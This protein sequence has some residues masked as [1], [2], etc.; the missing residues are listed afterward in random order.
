MTGVQNLPAKRRRRIEMPTYEYTE[1]NLA[2][3][4]TRRLLK[5]L[6]HTLGRIHG[7]RRI[8]TT[9]LSTMSV[10]VRLKANFD[11]GLKALTGDLGNEQTAKHGE[12]ESREAGILC[13]RIAIPTLQSWKDKFS[14]SAQDQLKRGRVTSKFALF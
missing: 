6:F 5:S 13:T 9:A 8:S 1:V 3:A 2:R 4:E 11:V 14:L 12:S 7:S 10:P